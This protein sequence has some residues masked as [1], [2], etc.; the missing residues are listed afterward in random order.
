[1]SLQA[2]MESAGS[3]NLFLCRH[4]GAGQAWRVASL[5]SN[6]CNHH[7]GLKDA[8]TS[9]ASF[10]VSSFPGTA[11]SSAHHSGIS[12]LSTLHGTHWPKSEIACSSGIFSPSPSEVSG[13]PHRK[14]ATIGFSS[15]S[16]SKSEP[17]PSDLSPPGGVLGSVDWLVVAS[18]SNL[19]W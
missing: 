15:G 9:P 12:H 1:M 4:G 11:D 13:D 19:T 6:S 10:L 2:K 8:L 14:E 17:P 16:S 7:G 3:M 5:E 18:S